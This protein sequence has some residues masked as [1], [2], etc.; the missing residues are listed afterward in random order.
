M[1][2]YTK[3]LLVVLEQRGALVV[4]GLSQASQVLW[5]VLDHF[6]SNAT[7][8][9]QQDIPPS[10]IHLL[11]L[12]HFRK[13]LSYFLFVFISKKLRPRI[14]AALTPSPRCILLPEKQTC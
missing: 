8:H 5:S 3:T 13:Q 9:Q 11:S 12:Y 14:S 6:L 2:T 10:K 7:P 4:V 1:S